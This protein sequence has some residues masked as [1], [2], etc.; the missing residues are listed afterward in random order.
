VT[1]PIPIFPLI[2]DK[3]SLSPHICH[4]RQDFESECFRR[5]AAH[6][7]QLFVLFKIIYKIRI[8]FLLTLQFFHLSNLVLIL[9]IDISFIFF[10]IY[11]ILF[12]HL[13]IILFYFYIIFDSHSF[14][15]Y[16]LN[17]FWIIE[18]FSS[19][20]LWVC[21]L[22]GNLVSWLESLVSKIDSI[23]VQFHPSTV[24]Y[25]VFNLVIFVA[26]LSMVLS[27]SHILDWELDE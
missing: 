14:D 16:F 24:G 22:L 12:F 8:L 4:F 18:I 10:L 23:W 17:F 20:F 13:Y 25:W 19:W 21:L 15:F 6:V 26:F 9:L 2:K 5:Y 27:Q 7:R 11:F 3:N 1:T